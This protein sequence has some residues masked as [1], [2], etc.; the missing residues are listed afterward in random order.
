MA[1]ID[2]T[3]VKEAPLRADLELP[4]SPSLREVGSLELGGVEGTEALE[5]ASDR[6]TDVDRLET[7]VILG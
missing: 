1:D 7:D 2:G 6:E 4:R 5:I 3:Y